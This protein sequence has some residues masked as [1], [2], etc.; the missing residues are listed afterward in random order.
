[1]IKKVLF[2]TI[3]QNTYLIILFLL[4][5]FANLTVFLLY[6]L[7]IEAFF[8]LE[9]I[10]FSFLIVLLF[11]SY[12][13]KKKKYNE[14]TNIE[15]DILNGNL[16]IIEEDNIIDRKY[17]EIIKKLNHKI[18]DI[19][20]SFNKEK[21]DIQDW[22]TLW[23]HQIKTPI[24]V[25]KLNINEKDKDIQ[26]ELFRIEEYANMALSYIRINSITNDLL[27]KEYSLDKIIRETL[28]KYAVQ[29]ISKKLSVEYIETDK[30][31]ITDKKWFSC[32]LEQ[33][34]S[35]AIK[36][37]E[38]GK[39]KIYVKNEKLI[40]EDTGIGI[41]KEDLPRIFEKSYSGINGRTN[42]KSSGLGL[43]LSK[44]VANLINEELSVESE[45]KKGSKFFVSITEKT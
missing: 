10:I 18:N 28:K 38:K 36:Y 12:F 44:I 9:I 22:Y 41:D 34:I 19:S 25:I 40:V 1:M 16:V 26:N 17:T 32:I 2:D 8:Y 3:R 20:N 23:L 42:D 29:F 15:E 30:I 27:I 31:I 4:M 21:D 45:I 7:V 37:T 14:L 11:I 13:K 6:H 43:Y 24:A 33:F 39:I 5:S 35:N